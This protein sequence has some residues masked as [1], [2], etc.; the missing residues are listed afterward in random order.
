M[1]DGTW[2]ILSSIKGTSQVLSAKVKAEVEIGMDQL[3]S[4]HHPE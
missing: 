3:V 2:S 4:Q 1:T